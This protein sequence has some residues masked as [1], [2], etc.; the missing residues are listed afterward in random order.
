[1]GPLAGAK[2]LQRESM[3]KIASQYG[4]RTVKLCY[5]AMNTTAIGAIPGGC[6][7]FAGTTELLVQRGRYRNLQALAR[8]TMPL[9]RKGFDASEMRLDDDYRTVLP[10]FHKLTDDLT[11]DTLRERL[12]H[13][14]GYAGL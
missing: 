5:P 9:F 2:V 12:S 7:M 1:M 3:A 14:V 8:E 4:V 13:V 10:D 11:N 6:L